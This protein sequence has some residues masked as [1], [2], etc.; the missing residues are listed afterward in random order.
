MPSNEGSTIENTGQ[1][2][3]VQVRLPSTLSNAFV[4]ACSGI[5]N[6][7]QT[8]RN[9]KIH[10]FCGLLVALFMM[11]FSLEPASELALFVCVSLVLSAELINTALEAVVNVCSP[12]FNPVAKIAKDAAAG[13]VLVVAIGSIL[14]LVS[15]AWPLFSDLNALVSQV[16]VFAIP[17]ATII[18][19][20][21]YLLFFKKG[22]KSILY[23]LA[24]LLSLW[25]FIQNA[26]TIASVALAGALISI[27]AL[28]A[29]REKATVA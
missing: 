4:F 6:T 3:A 13:A 28:C 29:L 27:S 8:Q 12:G 17:A 15:I 20:E 23:A 11:A 21:L 24:A 16:K 25:P 7:I 5:V 26:R 22:K 19:S 1:L 18:M 10:I 14:V 2:D 9:M